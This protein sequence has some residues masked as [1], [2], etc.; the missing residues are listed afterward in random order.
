MLTFASRRLLHDLRRTLATI[1]AVAI[2]VTSFVVLTGTAETQ[3]LT[4]TEM[5]EENFRGAYDVLVRPAGSANE[6]ERETSQ[7]RAS[8]LSGVYGGIT[9]D[10]VDR[11]QGIGGIEA[12]A[13]IAMIGTTTRD[14]YASLDITDAVAA[15]PAD[16]ERFVLRY[17]LRIQARGGSID[18][19]DRR[20]WVYVTR[21]P[22]HKESYEES[23]PGWSRSGDRLVEMID[24]VETHPCD[25]VPDVS[26][27]ASKPW[28]HVYPSCISLATGATTDISSDVG[29]V[30]VWVTVA[31]PLA[32]AAI[33]P[34]EEAK[35]VGLDDAV[36]AGRPLTADDTWHE[37]T[38]PGHGLPEPGNMRWPMPPNTPA[39]LASHSDADYTTSAHVDLL[40]ATATDSFVA[41]NLD[42]TGNPGDA[43]MAVAPEASATDATLTASDL[44]DAY[45]AATPPAELPRGEIEGED[46]ANLS[47]FTRLLKP[48]EVAYDGR[49]PLRPRVVENGGGR[50]LVDNYG[51]RT[52]IDTAF[53]PLNV[54]SDETGM[55]W[56][57]GCDAVVDCYSGFVLGTVGHFDP[58]LLRQGGELGRVPLEEYTTARIAAA[59]DATR[60]ALDGDYLRPMLHPGDYLQA[61][62]SILIPM[63]A[64]PLF[65][66]TKFKVV[67]AD[68]PISAVRV[69]VAGVTG[70]DAASR[71]R[72]R[73]VAQQ[74]V[75]RT[76]LDVDIVVGSSQVE[77][78]VALPATELGV[79]AL[80]LSEMWSQKGVGVAI[81]RALDAK[82][83]LLFALILVSSA[84][85][86][87][88]TAHASVQARRRELGVLACVGWRPARLR[89]EAL[90]ELALVGLA[91]GVVGSVAAWPLASALGVE[92]EPSRAALAIPIALVLTVVAGLTATRAAGRTDPIAAL[93]PPVATFKRSPRPIRSAA[94]LGVRQLVRRPARLVTGALAVAIATASLTLLGSIQFAFSGAVV[95]TFL[96]D[97]VAMQVRSADLIA[98]AFLALL[99]LVAVVTVLVLGLI[100][101][102]RSF[103][104]LSAIGWPDAALARALAAQAGLLGL[105]GGVAGAALGLGLVV[106]LVGTIVPATVGVAAAVAVAA[107]LVCLAGALLPAASLR[108]Q[109]VAQVLMVE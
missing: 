75:E 109:Q 32:V 12:V 83:L 97:V 106:L 52:A 103:A 23:G 66:A 13:P 89:G 9:L 98:A 70:M 102:A 93:R 80:N 3:R 37:G 44:F 46:W 31:F 105:I 45:L 25:Q 5:L 30:K 49:D 72:I 34:V 1:V 79:P 73:L 77:Q 21:A 74:I 55:Q 28:E 87:S 76:G 43:I 99:G 90:L 29:R 71:E 7:V 62:P 41:F 19:P 81:G 17:Q 82:S 63:Q 14:V 18:L 22:M 36:V 10:Q 78:A 100:E 35:L 96:G 38:R 20:G 16:R 84:L 60:D 50:R 53:R 2:A 95:G 26:E 101:D 57:S 69:R 107:V 54:V 59:D 40:P 64:L 39:L 24:G 68:A 91:A 104:T 92:F 33:D 67:D 8:F 94:G 61:P 42:G 65:T 56:T 85:T 11:I 27:P 47:M 58:D 6:I 48:G 88:L 86:V 4:V 51:P 15:V 108:R